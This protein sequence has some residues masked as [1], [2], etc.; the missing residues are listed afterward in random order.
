MAF[1]MIEIPQHYFCIAVTV[2]ATIHTSK[3][4][5]KFSNLWVFCV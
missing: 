2:L 5:G 1:G 3:K 4:M